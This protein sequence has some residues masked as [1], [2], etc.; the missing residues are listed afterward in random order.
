MNKTLAFVAFGVGGAGLVVGGITGLLALGKS[1]DL[2]DKCGADKN[3][4][5]A[6]S[7]SDIDSYKS[8]GTISTIGFIVAGVGGATGLVLLLTAPSGSGQRQRRGLAL[9]D[10]AGQARERPLDDAVLRRHLRRR[11][12]RLS[13]SLRSK[14]TSG[15]PLLSPLILAC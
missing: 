12:R 14:P 3:A 1:G 8:M 9:R 2:K 4:C 13:G 7:Q 15:R 11:D 10:G 6:D 5:P